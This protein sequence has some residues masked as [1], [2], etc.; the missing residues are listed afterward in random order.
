MWLF[1]GSEVGGVTDLG[2]IESNWSHKLTVPL[3]LS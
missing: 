2:S 1:L 3:T